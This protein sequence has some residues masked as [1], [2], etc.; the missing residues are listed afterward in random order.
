MPIDTTRAHADALDGM[1]A[2]AALC[3]IGLH[4]GIYSG[5]V[6]SSWLGI[7]EPGPLGPVLSR[8]TVGVP[9]F[10]VL[11]GL[12]LYRPYANAA[13]DGRRPPRAGRYLWHRALRILP[14]Y[15]AAALTALLLF[16][17]PW[18]G[19]PWP[20]ARTLLL[21]HIYEKD[22]IPA[23]V[24]QTWSLATEVAFYA[25]LPLLAPALHPLLRRRPAAAW[26]AFGGLGAVTVVSIVATHL[27][28]AG[29]YPLPALWLPEYLWYFAAG[30][31]LAVVAARAERTGLLPA[32]ARQ[33]ARRPWACWG[34]AL[35][36][37]AL[38]STPL[39][40]TTAEYPTVVQALAEHALYLVIAVALIAP[41]VF[42][43]GRGPARPLA[44]PVPSWL[45]RISY[46]IFLWHMIVVEAVLRLTGGSA[47]SADFTT[48]FA[49]TVAG[50]VA[51]AALSHYVLERPARRLRGVGAP[52]PEAVPVGG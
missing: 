40:G 44:G 49:V 42:A 34:V 52:R 6:A 8:L 5:Q 7:G 27:P 29:P 9:I 41:L 46:G 4:V 14:A 38:V 16:G 28:A 23:G 48:L 24:P 33:A 19:E 30:M 22:A 11:S 26:A 13:L 37:Y 2:I 39:T 43:D 35:A 51:L 3:V 50:S 47:G 18:L 15:W 17:R 25:V 12:L 36:A 20:V 10:F 1:R 21:L 45:G 31:A 32:A